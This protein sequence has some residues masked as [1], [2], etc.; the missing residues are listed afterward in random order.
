MR[1]GIVLVISLVLGSLCPLAAADLPQSVGGDFGRAWLDEFMK[2]NTVPTEEEKTN[3][4]WSW[5]GVPR[6]KTLVD[7]K[8]VATNITTTNWSADW[9][10]ERPLGDPVQI[11][12]TEGSTALS[13]LYLSSD[14][15]I[16]AQQLGRPVQANRDDYPEYFP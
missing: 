6:G 2:Y 15:W 13:P 3:D 5:G 14:P 16:R 4:L 9:L 10:G 8:L 1:M 11:N 12:A 7:G